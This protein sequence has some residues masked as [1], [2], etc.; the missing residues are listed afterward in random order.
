M[1][2]LTNNEIPKFHTP[3]CAR[4]KH[5]DG[6]TG[7]LAFDYIPDEIFTG[8]NNH[9]EPLEGQTNKIVFEEKE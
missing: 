2:A 9:A 1:G 5:Y 4:C 7:C 3:I 6:W 8:E